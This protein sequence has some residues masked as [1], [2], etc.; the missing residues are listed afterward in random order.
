MTAHGMEVRDTSGGKEKGW[1]MNSLQQQVLS[2]QIY[3]QKRKCIVASQL[4]RKKF[5]KYLKGYKCI[6]FK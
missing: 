1:I 6:A 4:K 2:K 5:L 3:E